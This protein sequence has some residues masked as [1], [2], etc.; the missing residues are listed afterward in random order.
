MPLLLGPRNRLLFRRRP[1]KIKIVKFLVAA[2]Y[3]MNVLLT[4]QR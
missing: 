2:G 1:L 4:E 3:V